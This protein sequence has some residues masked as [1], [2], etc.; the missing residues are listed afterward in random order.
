MPKLP[1][2]TIEL[3]QLNDYKQLIEFVME[4]RNEIFPM[5]RGSGVPE[6][7][8]HFEKNY[9]QSRNSAFFG[10]YIDGKIIGT[11]GII[12]YDGRF[13]HLESHCS[14]HQTSEL[15][16]CY[17][18][19]NFRRMGIGTALFKNALSYCREAG[20]NTIYLH[21]HPFLPGAVP[22]WKGCGF[23]EILSE[24]DPIWQTIHMVK[25]EV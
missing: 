16:K 13:S 2:Y 20:Y 15:V 5:L 3:V 1:Y 24:S 6:D 18:D 12:P 4:I 19:P 11:I 23:V 7:L 21:T 9:L 14:L 17:L 8:L 25:K 22:F 10:A